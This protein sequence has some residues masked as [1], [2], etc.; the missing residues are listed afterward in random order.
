MTRFL[1]VGELNADVVLKGDS[2]FRPGREMLVDDFRLTLGS[3]SAICASG[4]ARLGNDVGFVGLVGNDLLGRFCLDQLAASGVDV[5]RVVVDEGERTGVT[6]SLS[7]SEDRALATYP[8]AMER[9]ELHKL[10]PGF[11]H[12]HVSSYFLQKRL[13]RHLP[14]LF[15]AARARGSTTSLDPG[16][17]PEQRWDSGL[18][19]TLAEVDVFLPNELELS[20]LGHEIGEGTLVVVKRGSAG[21]ESRAGETRFRVPAPRVDVVDTTGAGDSFNAGFLH[22][23]KSGKTLQE[24]LRYGVVAGSL[25]TRSLGGITAQ[26][27]AEELEAA[28]AT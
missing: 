18:G 3:A 9:F 14:A 21:A 26:P 24:C 20:A 10:P 4:L 17:D 15:R 13:A 11:D 27:S 7:T 1:V 12:V 6:V 16:H 25:S 5:S 22:A 19:E 8:G 2:R 28:L 23:W